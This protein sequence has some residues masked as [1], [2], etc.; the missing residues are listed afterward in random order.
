[1]LLEF[2]IIFIII[3][4]IFFFV[5]NRHFE[6]RT[7]REHA[8]LKHMLEQISG[9]IS[10]RLN[11]KKSVE[12]T[13]EQLAVQRGLTAIREKFPDGIPDD[14]TKLLVCL[15]QLAFNAGGPAVSFKRTFCYTCVDK[16]VYYDRM[17]EIAK[18]IGDPTKFR[19]A[20]ESFRGKGESLFEKID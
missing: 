18:T 15:M 1:M 17:I 5:I 4:G 10:L 6:K 14:V 13:K 20:V 3:L 8:M 2:F 16:D 12:L 11:P 9:N 19:K 7:A